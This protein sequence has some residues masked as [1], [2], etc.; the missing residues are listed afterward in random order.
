MKTSNKILS[1]LFV[2]L[3]L[4]VLT[5][6]IIFHSSLVPKGIGKGKNII[7]GNGIS[8]KIQP[9]MI[10][11]SDLKINGSFEV[12]LEQGKEYVEIEGEENILKHLYI[13]VEENQ[14]LRIAPKKEYSLIPGKPIRIKI[15][16][17]SLHQVN[18]GQGAQLSN[19]GQLKLD[20]L[21]LKTYQHSRT[22]LNMTSK[23]L[24]IR[25]QTTAW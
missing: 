11:Y 18:L 4:V 20:Q 25:S 19:S 21:S 23:N 1:G 6:F 2:G 17:D 9:E 5:G 22:V 14:E 8:S 7:T 16:F 15:G 13:K 10:G 3:T 12:I 24:W